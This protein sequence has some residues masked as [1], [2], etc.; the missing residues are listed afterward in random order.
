MFGDIERVPGGDGGDVCVML[1]HPSGDEEDEG[2]GFRSQGQQVEMIAC[3][4]LW[5]N[6]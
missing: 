3:H 2:L 5:C 1:G 4:S 6:Y